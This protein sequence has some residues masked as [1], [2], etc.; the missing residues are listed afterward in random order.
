L[1]AAQGQIFTLDTAAVSA[2]KIVRGAPVV[3]LWNLTRGVL[4]A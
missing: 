2:L 4:P 3:A 1:P